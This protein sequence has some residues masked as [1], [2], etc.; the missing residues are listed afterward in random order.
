MVRADAVAISVIVP[1]RNRKDL[2][3]GLF[4]ALDRQTRRDFEVIVIDDGSTD[5]ADALAASRT[6]AGRP[7][8]LI[9]SHGAGAVAARTAGVN[10]AAG[11]ILAF[12]DSDCIP[13]PRWLEIGSAAIVDG[14]D[15]VN[16]RT[17]PARTLNPMERSLASGVEGLYPTANMF[18]RRSAF[19]EIGGFDGAAEHRLGFRPN[20]RSRGTGFGEDTILAWRMIRAGYEAR[21]VPE[22]EVAHHV[23]A[24]DLVEW[25]SRGWQTGAFPSLVSEVPELR[26]TMIWHKVQLGPRCRLPFYVT[27][28]AVVARRPKLGLVAFT[29]WT[30]LRLRDMRHQPDAWSRKL[31]YLPAEMALD[32]VMGTAM[33]IGSARAKTLVI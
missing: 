27:A 8:R 17:M 1:V 6:V 16:G 10:V 24:A 18:Y 11:E 15:L 33:V 5:G 9:R 4:D 29:W 13:D 23:F 19:D 28:L 25:L 7:V 14:A 3:E 26:D 22:A 32:T 21:Y 12:T 20:E 31:R 2:L 30:A